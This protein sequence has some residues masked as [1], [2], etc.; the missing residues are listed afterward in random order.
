MD[1]KIQHRNDKGIQ[2]LFIQLY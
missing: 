2:F 1:Y